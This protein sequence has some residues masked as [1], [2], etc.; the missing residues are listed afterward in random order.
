MASKG[1]DRRRFL[2]TTG[3]VVTGAAVAGTVTM[4]AAPNG[5]WALSLEAL[6]AHTAET[7]LGVTREIY[8]HDTLGDIYYAGVVEALD[9]K[10]KGDASISKMLEAG[11][12][13]LDGALGVAWLD[14]SDGN[15]LKTL[16]AIESGE[17]FQTVRGTT[18]GT[19]YNDPLVWRHFGYEGSSWEFGGYI[20]RGFNDLAWLPDVS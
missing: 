4:I 12:A 1:M 18:I 11:V 2:E 17:F 5:A 20:E 8:P 16:T 10:A 6:D 9:G 14:L 19:L 7:L 3:M 13:E 15:K